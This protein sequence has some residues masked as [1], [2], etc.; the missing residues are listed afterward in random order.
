MALPS[1]SSSVITAVSA[2]QQNLPFPTFIMGG[3]NA[4]TY[5]LFKKSTTYVFNNWRSPVYQIGK[6][7]DVMEITLPISPDLTTNMSI[8]P[9]LYFDN[10]DSNS[11]GATI[12]LTNYPVDLAGNGQRLIKLTSKN[13][14]NTTH[15][16]NNFFLELQFQGSALA[17]VGLP[18]NI[19][20][21]IED[22]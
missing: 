8:I 16:K 15:G 18:V 14:A 4:S 13:F 7:F 9:V 19:E 21:E 1:Y 20:I 12:N 2:V 3:R 6:N 10:E 5:K 17:V 11:V 22:T